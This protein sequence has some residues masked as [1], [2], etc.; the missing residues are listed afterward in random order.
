MFAHTHTHTQK[1]TTT[2]SHIT[3]YILSSSPPS[4]LCFPYAA[5]K[6]A[7]RRN[8]NT[9]NHIEKLSHNS[10]RGTMLKVYFAMLL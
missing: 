1:K 2:V 5:C 9:S 8:D 7:R 4:S 10:S 6:T 3:W